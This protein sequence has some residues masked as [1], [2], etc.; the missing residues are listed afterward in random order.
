MPE[1]LSTE[2]DYQ[3]QD[4]V[5][6]ELEN[7]S[8]QQGLTESDKKFLRSRYGVEIFNHQCV[9]SDINK[10][11]WPSDAIL[12]TYELDGRVIHDHVRGP[13]MVIVFD[14]YYD[15]LNPI[16]GK[17]LHMDPWYGMINPKLWNN[18]KPKK[19]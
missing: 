9:P 15:M 4:S 19:K 8:M 5:K 17:I 2:S 1:K 18:S 10:K 3:T 11:Q 16:G 7:S 13:K 6:T 14:A 12:I